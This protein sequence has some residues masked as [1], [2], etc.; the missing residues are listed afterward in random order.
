MV[1]STPLCSLTHSWR[2]DITGLRALAVLPVLLFHAFPSFLQGGFFGVDIFFVI[3]GFLISGIIFRGLVRDS[4]SYRAFYAKRIRR[5][6]PNLT[7]LLVAVAVTGWIILYDEELVNLGRHIYASA[8]FYQNFRLLGEVGYFTEDALRKPLLHLW[9]LAIEEQFYIVF[10]IVCALIWRFWKSKTLLFAASLLITIASL[11]ACLLVTDKNFAFYFPLTRFWELGAGILLAALETFG[12]YDFNRLSKTIRNGLSVVGFLFIVFAM[13]C[14]RPAIYGHPGVFTLL[15]IIGAVFLI[16]AQNDS[17]INRLFLSWRP[18]VFIGLISYSL[19]LWHWP[20]LSFLY[21]CSPTT[22][23]W[24]TFAALALSFILATLVYFFIEEPARRSK[25]WSRAIVAGLLF[26]LLAEVGVGQTF[27]HIELLPKRSNSFFVNFE[28]IQ[29]IRGGWG[30]HLRSDFFRFKGARV[31]TPTPKEIPTILFLGD[32]HMEQYFER[33]EVLSAKTGK[34]FGMINNV[35]CVTFSKKGC[36][37]EANAFYGL[38][39]DARIKTIVLAQKWFWYVAEQKDV[40]LDGIKGLKEAISSRPDIKVYVLLDYPWTPEENGHQGDFDP[41][42]H[43][44][45]FGPAVSSLVLP[46]PKDDGWKR[47]NDFMIEHLKGYVTFI[48]PQSYI[49]PGEKCDILTWYR[50]DDHLQP[51]RVR[52]HG[53]WLDSVF[54]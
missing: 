18:M 36:E 14:Y 29:R 44:S 52:T 38:I 32:S 15:P 21:I 9:S 53:V 37:K 48:D 34:T 20:L 40:L 50:D 42:R 30:A 24:V 23:H 39:K 2:D 8:A 27:R 1:A 7:V 17:V 12:F 13:T 51:K 28:T 41:L 3:S 49:C 33:A 5:I 35:L 16:A 6:L 31:A 10:P 46:Y 4:F 43:I 19:Y 54:E 25:R 11:A 26:V 45:R 47:G 22:P